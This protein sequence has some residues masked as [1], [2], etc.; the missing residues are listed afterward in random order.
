M[1]G[2]MTRAERVAAALLC[3]LLASCA[4]SHPCGDEEIC[5]YI[6]DDCDGVVDGPFRDEGGRYVH[7]EH[8]GACGVDCAEAFP[9]AEEVE[10]VEDEGAM[11]CVVARC[12]P[13][14]HL[15]FGVECV[16]DLPVACLPCEADE[17]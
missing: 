7:V 2:G 5:N 17:D 6:D 10:C 11:R 12:P 3:A 9:S 4:R 16:P 1:R 14:T 8:C 13:G 15:A